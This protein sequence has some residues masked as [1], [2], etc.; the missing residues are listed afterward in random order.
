MKE[1]KIQK[2]S[3]VV[4]KELNTTKQKKERTNREKIKFLEDF[5]LMNT[6][7]KERNNNIRYKI[8]SKSKTR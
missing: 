8:V 5:D 4:T 7:E 1:K 2:N 6:K 3:N